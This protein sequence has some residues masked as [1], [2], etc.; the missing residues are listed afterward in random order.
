MSDTP[1]NDER[2]PER[3]PR[4]G[5]GAAEWAILAAFVA[6]LIYRM[7]FGGPC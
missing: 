4:R 1:D 6:F 2:P 3:K 7:F 5:L